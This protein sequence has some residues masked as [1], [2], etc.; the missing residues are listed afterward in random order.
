MIKA[1]GPIESPQIGQI[2]AGSTNSG[3]PSGSILH[4]PD[5][6][7]VA[8]LPV[9]L[10]IDYYSELVLNGVATITAE[11]FNPLTLLWIHSRS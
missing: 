9:I 2:Q 3:T 7:Q 11:R 5:S 6:R 1:M 10:L 4:M 8:P